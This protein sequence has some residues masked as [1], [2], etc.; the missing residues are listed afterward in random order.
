M[1][2]N[3]P[4]IWGFQKKPLYGLR[5]SKSKLIT[6]KTKIVINFHRAVSK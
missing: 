5:N 2:R 1:A 4:N 6:M 3:T